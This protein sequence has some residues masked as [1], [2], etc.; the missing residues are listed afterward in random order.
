MKKNFKT[1]MLGVIIGALLV[2]TPVLA[3]VIWERIDVVRNQIT[4]MVGDEKLDADNFLY[5]DTTYVPIRKVA[6]G[7]GMNVTYK[8]GVAY[9]SEKYA[10]EFGGT[11][12]ELANGFEATTEELAAYVA[13][14]AKDP[15]Y[16]N[17]TAEEIE[18]AAKA[19]L[20][21]Y[22]AIAALA[23]E[24]GIVIGE[25][26]Y[27]N[28]SG[29][30]EYMKMNY[31]G[32]D[33][34]L[35]AMEEAG[36]TF[37]L[38]KR[39]QESD[40]LSRKLLALDK[41]SASEDDIKAYYEAHSAD[42]PYNGVQ[43]QHILIST[44]DENGTAITDEAKLKEIEK[45]ANDVYKEAK[46]GA[47]FNALIDKYGE[48]PGMKSNPEGYI[49][50]TGEMVEQFETTAFALKDGEISEPVKTVYGWHIIKRIKAHTSQPLT[51][52]LSANISRAISYD[53]LQNAINA[54]LAN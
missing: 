25:E 28:F 18:A 53:K 37:E 45:K 9:I 50:T 34:M 42:F 38:Y 24:N 5:R 54:K 6:E 48:D 8:D 17:A 1:L 23:T 3:D 35:A 12:I 16:A 43:A 44:M 51:E 41:F 19:N 14:T 29:I 33:S 31:G 11:K 2:G 13:R 39:Y 52:S 26:F 15:S 32:E 40:Y 27:D 46:G 36:Y 7:L 4:V 30:I 21:Q 20:I 49:F 22:K 10:A 47:D